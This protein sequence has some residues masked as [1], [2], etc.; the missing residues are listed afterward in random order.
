MDL[1]SKPK[2]KNLLKK[3]RL[4]PSKGLGQNFLVNRGAVN[5]I[6]NAADLKPGDIVLEIGPG[7]GVL[8]QA[9]VEKA[10]KVI[11]VEKDPNLARILNNEL[12][13]MKVKNVKVIQGDI[14][15]IL[16]SKLPIPNSY[17]VIAN[18]PF[19]LTAPVIRKFLE[20]EAQ[21]KLM[22]LIIQKEVAQRICAKV[23]DMNLLA[24][25]VQ[26]YAQPKV[27]SYIPRK[28]F[29]PQPEVDAAIIKIVPYKAVPYQC[30]RHDTGLRK[31]FFKIVRSGFSQ[32]RKQLINNLFEK[33]KVDKIK[34]GSWLWKSNI[35][36]SQRAE[37][38]S[39]KDWLKL[40]KIFKSYYGNFK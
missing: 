4:R 14:L 12:K 26:F 8:T 7:L 10:K 32:P 39:I 13:R 15:K 28:S 2:V 24:V 35:Q 5:R 37:T 21:P 22:V 3:Y 16:N 33:L 34:I 36:P 20:A 30:L 27:I 17:K 19:Y 1:A 23:P 31:Q 18:L 6:I 40:T 38:L 11:A 9:L 29:W 25:S